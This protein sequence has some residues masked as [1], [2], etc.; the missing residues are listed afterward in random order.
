MPMKGR[1]GRGPW[2]ICLVWLLASCSSQPR[3]PADVIV[4][5]AHGGGSALAFAPDSRLLASGGWSGQLKLWRVPGLEPVFGWKAHEGQVT[6]VGFLGS[7]DR[8]LSAGYD[9]R[10]VEWSLRGEPRRQAKAEREITAFA[11]DEAADLLVTGHRG[12]WV[13]QWGLTGLGVQRSLRPHRG[14]VR[15]VAIRPGGGGFA[16]SGTDGRVFFWEAGAE[17]KELTGQASDARTLAFSPDARLLYGAGWFQVFRWDPG[18]GTGEALATEHLGIINSI[19][20]SGD[21]AYLASISRQTDSAVLFQ[22]P[23]TGRTL[24]RFQSHDLC[25][26]VVSLSRDG[27]Y[28]ATTSDDASIRLWRLDRD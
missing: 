2:L 1:P 12:G 5:D 27:R 25:G 18:E 15:A 3:Q 21:G 14:A 23:E 16:S 9:G 20:F 24:H 6:G 8:L 19:T 26:A 7:G 10:I 22:D 17:P 13:I 28:L 4:E 11:I